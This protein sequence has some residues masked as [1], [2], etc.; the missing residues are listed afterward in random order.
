MKNMRL[1]YELEREKIQT[2]IIRKT[3]EISKLE[4]MLKYYEAL[5]AGIGKVAA[6]EIANRGDNPEPTKTKPL[7]PIPTGGNDIEPSK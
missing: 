4:W 5:Q 1:I 6:R 7:K 3:A 2:A